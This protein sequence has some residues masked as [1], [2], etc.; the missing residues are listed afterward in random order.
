MIFKK[1]TPDAEI[2]LVSQGLLVTLTFSSIPRSFFAGC[3]NAWL[4]NDRS[5]IQK[6]VPCLHRT[7]YR[8][9]EA[10]TKRDMVKVCRD[11]STTQETDKYSRAQACVNALISVS[12]TQYADDG[13]NNISGK[14]QNC[15]QNSLTVCLNSSSEII[16]LNERHGCH[17][18][19][20]HLTPH[21]Y[22]QFGALLMP[23]RLDIAHRDI[24]PKSRRRNPRCH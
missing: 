20:P 11:C 13:Q 21:L 12:A 18:R 6:L 5:E 10:R 2:M 22:L 17:H 1:L 23:A 16:W 8:Y 24:P 9:L 3:P 4:W 7:T 14:T 19:F 15:S